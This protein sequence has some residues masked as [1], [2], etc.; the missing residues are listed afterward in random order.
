[1]SPSQT[2][3]S[4]APTALLFPFPRAGPS[5]GGRQPQWGHAMAGAALGCLGPEQGHSAVRPGESCLVTQGKELVMLT[6]GETQKGCS[7]C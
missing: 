4:R 6:L 3:C 1:M 7:I 5:L 2:G